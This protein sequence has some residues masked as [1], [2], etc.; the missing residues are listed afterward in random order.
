MLWLVLG[1]LTLFLF[2]GGLRAFERAS[3]TTVKSLVVWMAALG[4]LTLALLLVLT[5]RGGIALGAL[6]LFGPLIWNRWRASHPTGLGTGARG[7]GT[8]TGGGGEAPRARSGAMTRQE[9]YQVLGL[10][11]G[12]SEAD[13][14]AAHHRLMRTAHP[15][16]GGSD[17]LAARVNMAR[18]VLLGPR[19]A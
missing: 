15:D 18:D 4:G 16:T 10:Q 3:V 9:A 8:R 7:A 14:R 19:H 5:G 17:W 2:L 1:G 11:P 12:A 13:I 6:A